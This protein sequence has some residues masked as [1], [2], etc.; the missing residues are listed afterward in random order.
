MALVGVLFSMVMRT[1]HPEEDSTNWCVGAVLGTFPE[2]IA[3]TILVS[4]CWESMT[5]DC[6]PSSRFWLCDYRPYS[7]YVTTDHILVT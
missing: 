4:Y 3:P 2:V 5:Q 7:G 6:F 1:G